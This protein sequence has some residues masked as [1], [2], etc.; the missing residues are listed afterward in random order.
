MER[1]HGP[2]PTDDFPPSGR[3]RRRARAG[4]AARRR[5]WLAAACA[6]LTVLA[7]AAAGTAIWAYTVTSGLNIATMRAHLPGV[8]STILD[9]NGRQLAR[10]ASTQN[11]IPVP[12]SQI[13]P[14]L[15]R[16]TV[17]IED[18]RFYQHGGVD[19]QATLRALWA[20]VTA[21]QIVQGGSTIEQ[22]LAKLLYLG[23]AQTLTRKVQEAALANQ[24]ADRWSKA[25][26]LST[27][28]NVVPYG[29]VTYGCEAAARAYFATHCATLTVSQAA[30]LAGLPRSPTDYDPHVDPV[31][32]RQRRNEVLAAM[33]ANGDISAH[34]AAV[35]SRRPLDL[36]RSSRPAIRQAYFVQ[37]VEQL[38]RQRYGEQRLQRGGLVVRTTLDQRLQ[39]AAHDAFHSVLTTPGHPAAAL[40][41]MDPHT[42]AVLAF[43]ASTNPSRVRYDLPSQAHRQAGSAFKPFGLLAAMLDFHIDPETTSYSAAAPFQTIL[44]GCDPAFPS[45]VWK[46]SNAEPGGSGALTLHQALD[47]SVN[48][49]FARLSMDIGSD[50]TVD[51]AYRLGIPRADHLP[52]VPS[53]VLGTGLVSPL[54]MT[55]AYATLA[56]GGVRHHP[57][58]I[59]Q[60]R[61]PDGSVSASSPPSQNPGRRVI[62]DW[63]ASEVTS[64]LQD[65]ITCRLGLCTGGGALLSPPR[66]QAGKTGTVEA[67]L[68]AWFCGY[69][70]DIA[71][72]VWMGFPKSERS[73]ISAVGS[74]ASFGGGYPA[75]MWRTFMTGAIASEPA[76]FPALGFT[77]VPPPAGWYVPWTSHV[78]G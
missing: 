27:Y 17:A 22:Q 75:T 14:W 37:Y 51:M 71:A 65:N 41:A 66:P 57:L 4:S 60:V 64:I 35:L 47:G 49:V 3:R 46:V 1:P 78:T 38:L 9:T 53:I 74:A 19:Y 23:G 44:P 61:S 8:N 30:L 36:A 43:D 13:S 12:G 73:M 54:D 10:I 48:A 16:A 39:Q 59:T 70:P 20:D 11:R 62:P 56:D 5:R 31:A 25:R 67:H 24:I 77:S 34:R 69:T 42:G 45:C 72:C 55:T 32:A 76:R 68:D 58:A 21:G 15:K 6:V 18:R 2:S 50:P 33:A 52:R 40:V 63:A 28:L 26:I 29:G 7:A